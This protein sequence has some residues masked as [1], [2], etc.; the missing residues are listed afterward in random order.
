[1]PGSGV[2]H[3]GCSLNFRILF[4]FLGSELQ[5]G[6]GFEEP[7]SGLCGSGFEGAMF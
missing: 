2:R 3:L 5:E 6:S 7:D 4:P 1:M